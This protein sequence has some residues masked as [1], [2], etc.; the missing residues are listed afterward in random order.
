M[1]NKKISNVLKRINKKR[2]Q[3]GSYI[4]KK[5]EI[6]KIRRKNSVITPKE[7]TQILQKIDELEAHYEDFDRLDDQ[8]KKEIISV[9]TFKSQRPQEFSLL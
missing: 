6:M 8:T 1:K 7:K 9:I 2:K 4:S 5:A 3:L